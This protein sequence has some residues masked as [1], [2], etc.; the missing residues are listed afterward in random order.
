[1]SRKSVIILTGLAAL[2]AST[3]LWFVGSTEENSG[4]HAAYEIERP[5]HWRI[6]VRNDSNQVLE[7]VSINS[8]IPVPESWQQY[9]EN[10]ESDYPVELVTDNNRHPFARV[11]IDR[12]PPY[13]QREIRLTA[14]LLMADAGQIPVENA[15]DEWLTPEPLVES[16]HPDIIQLASRLQRP[17]A[18]DSAYAIYRWLVREIDDAGY[19]PVD[20]GALY[21]FKERQGDCTEYASLAVALA[22]A[23][24]L[25][26]RMVGGYVVPESGHLSF[27]AF[28]AWAEILVDDR[29][30]IVDGQRRDYDPDPFGYVVTHYGVRSARNMAW[31]R[32]FTSDPDITL[33]MQ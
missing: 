18:A 25:P 26:A 23:M 15:S 31:D 7:Q 2:L 3:G 28:H 10:L 4:L 5:L 6:E 12:I 9:L 16:D 11:L 20:R 17:E 21:A 30:V 27:H 29:W 24:E 32:F 13:G 1:M 14:D 19:D 22:R 8:F 33:S